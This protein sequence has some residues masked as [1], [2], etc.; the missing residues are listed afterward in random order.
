VIDIV[1]EGLLVCMLS[2]PHMKTITLLFSI[3]F[4][5]WQANAQEAID[6]TDQTLKIGGLKEE[7]LYF[8]FAAGDKIIFNFKEV[9]NKELKELEITEYP[10]S[11]KFSD[12]RTARVENKTIAVNK[13]GVYVFR[14]KNGAITGRVCKIQIQRVPA[15]AETKN[16]NTSVTWINK[17]D[18]TWNT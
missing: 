16:F 17:Q 15:G 9:N 12:F 5:A 6:V 13:E 8:G 4:L 11:S 18:T 3:I 2:I 1:G 10:L 14:F 7:E